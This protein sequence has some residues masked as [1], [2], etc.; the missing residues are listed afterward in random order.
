MNK[1]LLFIYSPHDV[2]TELRLRLWFPRGMAQAIQ[3]YQRED[4]YRLFRV[5]ALGVSGF[6]TFLSETIT[7]EG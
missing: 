4:T 7:D 1:P 3:S 5:P 2:D 6:V